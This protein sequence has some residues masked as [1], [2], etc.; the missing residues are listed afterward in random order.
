MGRFFPSSHL[1]NVTLLPLEKMD[2]SVRSFSC[3]HCNTHHD[4]DIN[5]AINIRNEGLRILVS[6]CGLGEPV[7]CQE[8]RL[9]KSCLI[10]GNLRSK[11]CPPLPAALSEGSPRCG[12]CGRFPPL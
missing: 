3:P 12:D 5:A 10:G 1:C 6:Q 7:R 11:L 2:L 8:Q 4:R 9:A